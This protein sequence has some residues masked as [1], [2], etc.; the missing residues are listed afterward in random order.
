MSFN[1]QMKQGNIEDRSAM[2]DS[3]TGAMK[4]K[5]ADH[6]KNKV[7]KADDQDKRVL[8]IALDVPKVNQIVAV[9]CFIINVILP[10]FGTMIAACSA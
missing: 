10:G 7:M 3:R 4:E 5:I 9:I 1:N 6:W 8:E 2:T